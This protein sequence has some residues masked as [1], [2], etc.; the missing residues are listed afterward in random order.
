MLSK[1]RAEAEKE[2]EKE[3]EEE[4]EFDSMLSISGTL[5][6]SYFRLP[7]SL[8]YAPQR[9]YY[10][11]SL[12]SWWN[13]I[14]YGSPWPEFESRPYPLVDLSSST[15]YVTAFVSSAFL[16]LRVGESYRN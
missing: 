11:Y 6:G 2:D 7:D 10:Y 13:S 12:H 1:V 8:C 5:N 15:P 3:E 14:S 16:G 4:E 9:R